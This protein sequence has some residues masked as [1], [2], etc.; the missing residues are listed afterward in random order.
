MPLLLSVANS[1]KERWTTYVAEEYE[2]G[3]EQ[4]LY[5]DLAELAKHIAS[6]ESSQ[7]T[8]ELKE[9]FA[10]VERILENG[11]YAASEAITVGLLEDLWYY[12]GQLTDQQTL[13]EKHFGIQTRY[14]YS[15]VIRFWTGES[16]FIGQGPGNPRLI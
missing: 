11:T 5:C 6:P 9:I 10:V 7:N 2:D 1:F 3:E 12:S 8:Q 13:F 4:L 14:W 15:E 16:E